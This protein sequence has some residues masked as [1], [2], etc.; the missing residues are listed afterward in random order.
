VESHDPDDLPAGV[1]VVYTTRRET[2]GTTKPDPDWRKAFAPFQVTTDLR[3]ASPAAVFLHDLPAHR[4]EEV[5]TGRTASPSTRRRTSCPARWRRRNGAARDVV[6]RGRHRA[7]RGETLLPAEAYLRWE[8]SRGAYTRSI[9]MPGAVRSEYG[10]KII[11]ASVSNPTLGLE[12]TGGIG[13][14]FDEE[15]ARITTI[16]GVGL[17]SA[18]RTAAVSAVGIDAAGYSEA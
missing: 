5:T 13:L 8:N 12:R 6:R 3:R 17:L 7:D 11:N 1:D 10:M 2:T 4:G 16:M 15:T 18:V 9:S 14:T